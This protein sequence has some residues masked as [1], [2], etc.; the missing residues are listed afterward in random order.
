[1][2]RKISAIFLSTVLPTVLLADQNGLSSDI[3][4]RANSFK[5]DS[6][7][8]ATSVSGRE[9]LR[10]TAVNETASLVDTRTA[11]SPENFSSAE[12]RITNEPS[13]LNSSLSSGSNAETRITNEPSSLNS[14]LSSGSNAETRITNEPSSLESSQ[15]SGSNASP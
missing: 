15:S 12:T 4:N 1:M 10:A 3:L 8:F 7:A 11:Q 6:A 5:A 2:N 14:S 9:G 13:S